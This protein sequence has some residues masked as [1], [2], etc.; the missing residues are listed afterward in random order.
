MHQ[1]LALQV[2]W[3]EQSTK[4]QTFATGRFGPCSQHAEKLSWPPVCNDRLLYE[5]IGKDIQ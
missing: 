2:A 4:G 5:L 3:Q 1:I